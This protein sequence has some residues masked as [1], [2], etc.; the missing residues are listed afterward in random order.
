M[1]MGQR[2][3]REL[4]VSTERTCRSRTALGLQ[5]EERG[6]NNKIKD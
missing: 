1:E 6:R 5:K 3:E 2:R 4:V